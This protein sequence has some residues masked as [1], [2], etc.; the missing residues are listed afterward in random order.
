M[1]KTGRAEVLVKCLL[2]P[3]NSMDNSEDT[4]NPT[5]NNSIKINIPQR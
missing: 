3:W 1:L 2:L 4:I 5:V